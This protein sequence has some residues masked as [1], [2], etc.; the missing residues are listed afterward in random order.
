MV[1][2]TRLTVAGLAMLFGL[3]ACAGSEDAAAPAPPP[4]A[5]VAEQTSADPFAW[6]DVRYQDYRAAALQVP[7]SPELLVAPAALTQSLDSLCHTDSAGFVQLIVDHESK[8]Q[9]ASQND[10]DKHLAEEVSLR[11]GL[12]CPQR[13]GDWMAARQGVD[14]SEEAVTQPELAPGVSAESAPG[15]AAEPTVASPQEVDG[16][17]LPENPYVESEE[18]PAATTDAAS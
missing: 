11:L 13:M 14:L 15:E 7:I 17:Q 9:A 12:A 18:Q 5:A 16:E 6:K 2:S 8:A 10:L 4:A 3:A 1:G